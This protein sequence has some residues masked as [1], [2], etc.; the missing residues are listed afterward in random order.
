M[1]L[2]TLLTAA[3]LLSL[4]FNAALVG[5]GYTLYRIRPLALLSDPIPPQ[6]LEALTARLPGEAGKLLAD[7]LE[8]GRPTLEAERNGYR[9]ALE[10]AA[11]LIEA[12]VVDAGALKAA[13]GEARGHRGRMGDVYL[14]AFVDMLVALPFADRRALV[15]RFRRR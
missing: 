4:A 9:A 5:Y 11:G 8:A 13:I 7:R 2:R 3:L 1:R 6:M 14:D 12:D 10:R 15:E